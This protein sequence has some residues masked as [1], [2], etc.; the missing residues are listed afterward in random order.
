MVAIALFTKTLPWLGELNKWHLLQ[1]P[2]QMK[3]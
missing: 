3:H 1:N 2:L